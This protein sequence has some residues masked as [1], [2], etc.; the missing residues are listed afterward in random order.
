MGLKV[1]GAGFGRTGTTSLKAA[2]EQLGYAPCHHMREVLPDKEQ[3]MW[4][5]QASKKEAIEWDAVFENFDAAVDWPAAAYYKELAEHFPDAK[6]IL[7]V[8]DAAAWYKSTRETIY[9][10]TVNVPAWLCMAVP[11]VKRAV[12]MVNRTIWDG[13]FNGQFEN[14]DYAIRIYEKHLQEVERT[15]PKERLLIHSP[16]E[17][18]EPLCRFL[19]KPLPEN[20]YPRVNE[21]NVIKR[22]VLALNFLR[23]LPWLI[24]GGAILV[25]LVP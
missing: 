18:W 21:A 22:M 23:A 19:E 24:V 1:I 25:F 17:G 7:S 2:L 3:V 15:I 11:S 8:R 9:P 4:F 13:I 16:N 20:P 10:A 12:Q 5:D 6:V 14:R